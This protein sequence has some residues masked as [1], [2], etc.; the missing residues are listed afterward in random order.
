[1]DDAAD[2]LVF[3][4]ERHSSEQPVNVAGGRTVTIRELA[5]MVAVACGW[6]GRFVYDTSKADGMPRKALDATRLMAMGWQPSIGLEE[7]LART[8]ESF[9]S[10]GETRLGAD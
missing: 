2:A 6:E 1:M 9:Q 10:G 5:E 7:G 4:M 3:L 8:C